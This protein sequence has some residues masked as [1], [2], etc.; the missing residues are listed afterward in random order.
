MEDLP[1]KPKKRLDYET[2]QPNSDEL[3]E[4]ISIKF[5]KS[6]LDRI[7][8]AAKIIGISRVGFIT[9]ASHDRALLVIAAKQANPH[10][11]IASRIHLIDEALQAWEKAF[12]TPPPS[13]IPSKSTE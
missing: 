11:S 12:G 7:T 9:K 6:K 8:Q 13:P 5:I 10:L 3:K 2:K 4:A 1:K